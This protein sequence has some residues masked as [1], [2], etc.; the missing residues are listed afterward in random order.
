M[1]TTYAG[2]LHSLSVLP[3]TLTLYAGTIAAL[4]G[5]NYGAVRAL[6]TDALVSASINTAVSTKVPV[7]TRI[8]PW[9]AIPDEIDLVALRAA[10]TEQE[11]T[12]HLLAGIANGDFRKRRFAWS[13]YLF[14][15]LDGTVGRHRYAEL[16]DQAEMLFSLILVDLILHLRQPV[17]EPW[18]GRFVDS[19]SW[20]FEDSAVGRFLNDA[21]T[22]GPAWPPVVAGM[23]DGQP[24]RARVAVEYLAPAIRK[25]SHRGPI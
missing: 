23:F 3:A 15:V 18:L 1:L 14:N 16:F 12:D 22:Q 24:D 20:R 19:D 21:A 8:G 2:R 11:L 13:T 5:D 9:D 6:T 17:V 7:I 4:D 25:A 10:Q